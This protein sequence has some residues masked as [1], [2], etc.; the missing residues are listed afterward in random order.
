MSRIVAN[1]DTIGAQGG[2]PLRRDYADYAGD[3][4][5]AA[6]H[7]LALVDDLSD[8]QTVERADFMIATEAIDLADIARRA[9]GLLAVR[10]SD[11][12]VRIDRPPVQEALPAQG[13][14]RRVLQILVNLIGNA[15]R[16]SPE[17][18]MIWLRIEREDDTAMVIVADQGKGIARRR[19]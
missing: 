3:I 19:P 6:R 11:G 1:A 18:A 7:L 13:D 14:F 4:A 10:A 16:Y 9:A 8:L 17:G 15:V 12:R 2:G 5:S